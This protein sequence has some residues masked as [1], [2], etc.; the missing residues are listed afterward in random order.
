MSYDYHQND[1]DH[2][3]YSACLQCHT[4]CPIKC[5][6]VNG[7]LVKIDGNPF[8]PQSLVQNVPY[9]SPLEKGAAV[10]GRICPKGQSGIET[11]YDP[12]RVIKV[13]KR[14][15][16][17]QRG[18]GQWVTIDFNKAI[19]EIIE[20]GDLFGEGPVQGLK[21]VYA[22]RDR[23][24]SRVM[25][26]D[27]KKIM[28]KAMTV[29]EF[30]TKHA[31][32]L[33][34]LIDPDHPDLGPKNNQFVFL[35][36][37]IQDGR[38]QLMSW[39]T[40]ESFGSVNT[41][42]HTTICEQSHHIAFGEMTNKWKEGKWGGGSGHMKP[43]FG[44]ARFVI[45]FGTGFSEANFG[46]PLLSQ[47]T[48]EGI[49]KNGLKI[50]CVDPRLSRSAGKADWWIPIKP[51]T[52][53]AFAMGM[54]RWIIDN[55]RFD[56]RHLENANEAAAKADRE[57]AWTAA[58][59]LVKIEDGRPSMYLRAKELG[60]GTNEEFVV[61]RGGTLLAV[62]PNDQQKQVEGD[63]E[64]RIEK[65]GI[66]AQTAFELFRDRVRELSLAQYAEISG[67]SEAII[68]EMAKEFT[69]YG[70]QAG[71]ELYRGAV[72]HTNGYYNAQAIIALNVLIGNSGWKGGLAGGG[73]IWHE[74]GGTPGTPYNFNSMHPGWFSGF[75]TKLS[76]ERSRFEGEYAL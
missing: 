23:S 43:D 61:S 75:G 41:Y 1:P 38:T 31:A 27:V 15:P 67:V 58:S 26:E 19:D 37:R 72:Q 50:A 2:I 59:Y 74:F 10:E 47:L 14:K 3:I 13:L 65:D 18:T 24:V 30:K 71:A 57:T 12:Y 62:N 51:G 28:K 52:D 49:I 70:K 21:E 42:E 29:E 4:G 48:S 63:L 22:I 45:F 64:A 56:K 54:A 8:C 35:A 39:F 73:G 7:V 9:Q 68:V 34:G 5:K 20:G 55:N 11:L 6:V 66:V 69:S 16:G 40:Y 32:N 36:G 25:A 44:A 53:G 46:P 60:I 76:R 33:A 17:T